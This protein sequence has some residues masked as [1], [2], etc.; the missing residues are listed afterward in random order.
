VSNSNHD[1][2]TPA[3][4]SSQFSMSG[5]SKSIP[6]HIKDL[7]H[8]VRE[9]NDRENSGLINRKQAVHELYNVGFNHQHRHPELYNK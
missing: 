4:R 3:E 5:N 6:T 2:Y 1:G 9:V 7:A 8:N